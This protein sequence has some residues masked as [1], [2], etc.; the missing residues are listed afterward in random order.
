MTRAR[1]VLTVGGFVFT[2]SIGGASLWHAIAAEQ[3]VTQSVQVPA[4]GEGTPAV[5]PV[6]YQ[7]GDSKEFRT[8]LQYHAG[9]WW[10]LRIRP[11]PATPNNPAPGAAIEWAPISLADH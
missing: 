7:M 4:A 8:V 11:L 6:T 10:F 1:H 2:G 3:I 9:R 5:V